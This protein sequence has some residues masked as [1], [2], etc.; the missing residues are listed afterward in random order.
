MVRLLLSLRRSSLIF[1]LI[2]VLCLLPGVTWAQ[3][4]DTPQIHL[5]VG[6][7]DPLREELP[8]SAGLDPA[9]AA[10][11]T[12][13]HLVQFIGPVQEDWKAAV[14]NL[15]AIFYDYLPDFAFLVRVDP[16]VESQV[17]ELPFVRWVGP[18]RASYRIAPSLQSELAARPDSGPVNL[19][20]QTLPDADFD[21]LSSRIRDLG[22]AVEGPSGDPSSD[23]FRVSLPP[24]QVSSLAALEGVVWVEPYFEPQLFNDV[25]G[26]TIMKAG[27]VRSAF[28]LYGSGQIV[29]VADSG[30]DKGAAGLSADFAGRLVEG[31]AICVY[32]GGRDTW[33]DFHGH[34]THVSG[35][36]L[37]N[38]KLS[39]SNPTNHQYGGSYA[40][41]APE[42]RLVFQAIDNAPG[43]GLECVPDDLFN[44]IFKPAYN[45]GARIHTNSWG[46]PTGG[47]ASS[48]HYG[49][50]TS[51]SKTVDS[52]AWNLDDLLILFAAGNSGVDA[53][54]DGFI[55]ADSLASPA[56]AKN[57]ITVGASE[58]NRPERPFT[59]GSIWPD[60]YPANP[61]F[62][63][64]V[65]NNL[66]GMAAFSSRGPADD[67]RIKPDLVAPGTFII[68]ARSHDPSAGTGWGTVN[69]DYMYNGGTSMSTPLVAGAAALVR[70]WLSELRGFANPS[71]ALM[72]AVLINGAADMSPG[73]YNSPQEIPASR[74]N[75]VSGWGRIDLAA[76]LNPPSPQKIWLQ[77]YTTGL[78][79]GN[80]V[81]FKLTTGSTQSLSEDSIA[82]RPGGLLVVSEQ[83]TPEPRGDSQGEAPTS[84]SRPVELR[85]DS[86]DAGQGMASIVRAPSASQ[87]SVSLVLDDG[88]LDNSIGVV[89][90]T[91]AYQFIWL[92]RFT[93]APADFPFTLEEIQ[94]MFYENET[95]TLNVNVGDEIEL[96]VYQDADGDPS[97][98]AALLATVSGTVQAVNGSAW[99]VYNLSSPVAIAGPGDVLI[100]VINRYV[101]D[102]VTA[103]SYPA[104][105]DTAAPQSRSWIGWWST[106]PPDS[107][108]L[109]PDVYFE[110]VT[111]T[112]NDG[113]WLVR[114]YG[115]T[116]ADA[117]PSPT[118]TPTS[119]PV[120]TT[121][122]PFRVSLVWTDFPGSPAA[123]KALVNNLDLEVIAPDG[124]HYYGNT[125]VYSA[126]HSCLRDGKWDK[127]NNVEGVLI[128]QALNGTY[129]V[130]VHG[131]N[132]PNGPQ[133]FALVAS[134]DNL[135][136][137]GVPG[138][139]DNKIF[140][141]LAIH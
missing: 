25:G 82:A 116:G 39:N 87:A 80:N 60:D 84:Q 19:V 58:N 79:T 107:P 37:G 138:T 50:Y 54:G 125:G 55:D 21:R 128:P 73:Q 83:G 103:K 51:D 97:N 81:Q 94:V 119:T 93:P 75:N 88:S 127:C 2:L 66:N 46:G 8:L 136:E 6:S 105:I 28:G 22:A 47:T 56:T 112:A 121:G 15:G 1:A 42:A 20:V 110:S 109:P 102:G 23:T 40:G 134:G 137:P 124:K 96:A 70:E 106:T 126:G 68:S 132:V 16:G 130:I 98:G 114:G 91:S 131:Y 100:G 135:A 76:S 123:S 43:G 36:V 117:T 57:A 61:I 32:F 13:M 11:L 30:L 14:E 33:N 48:P 85:I 77:D 5:Q 35:S 31:Q 10:D 49:G 9:T 129:T 115:Q 113:N 18:Y 111:G 69:G 99:S 59:W 139:L 67:G 7:F 118:P 92:N 26:G 64:S 141:P 27:T 104:N 65:S 24:G 29:A 44:F 45:L 72:K 62:Q 63:D 52:T 3:V 38:G 53:N 12:T 122:G 86:V 140:L 71:A 41:V 120:T 108:Q 89:D 4:P 34:G 90:E 133:P 78:T 101:M 74:P 17:A 95:G